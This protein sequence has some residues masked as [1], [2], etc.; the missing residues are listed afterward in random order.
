MRELL[1]DANG[2]GLL[3]STKRGKRPTLYRFVKDDERIRRYVKQE[4]APVEEEKKKKES[5]ETKADSKKADKKKAKPKKQDK[6]KKKSPPKVEDTELRRIVVDGLESYSKYPAKFNDLLNFVE[7][8]Q[9]RSNIKASKKQLRDLLS[10]A[11][12]GG[13]LS[14]ATKRGVRPTKYRFTENNNAIDNYLG[15]PHDEVIEESVAAPDDTE[16][17]TGYAVLVAAIQALLDDGRSTMI[18]GP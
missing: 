6:P 9:Q 7:A 8:K 13:V 1:S 10:A 14:I 18:T 17:T 16:P 12:R 15:V 2:A 3:K 5:A 11:T 4:P